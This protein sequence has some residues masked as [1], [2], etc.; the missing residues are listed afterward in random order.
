MH[1]ITEASMYRCILEVFS[2][3]TLWTHNNINNIKIISKIKNRVH[4][5]KKY[6]IVANVFLESL[7]TN[8][9]AYI[10]QRGLDEQSR[11]DHIL[12]KQALTCKK[13]S[14]AIS[15]VGTIQ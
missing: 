8:T 2:L 11:D 5:L 10:R 9:A 3:G 6:T 15:K 13:Y 7:K 12:N 14:S 1:K 4:C